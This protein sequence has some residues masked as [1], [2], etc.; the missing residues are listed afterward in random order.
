MP[1]HGD[2][3]LLEPAELMQQGATTVPEAHA[4]MRAIELSCVCSRPR[5][6]EFRANFGRCKVTWVRRQARTA[7]ASYN[8]DSHL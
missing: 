1:A 4:G 8:R 3:I 6:L 2:L 7:A 5:N